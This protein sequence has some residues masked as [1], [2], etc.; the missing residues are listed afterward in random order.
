MKLKV[1]LSG[2]IHTN[3]RDE[4]IDK[5]RSKNLEIAKS[6]IINGIKDKLSIELLIEICK[7]PLQLIQVKKVAMV[8]S[9]VK[10]KSDLYYDNPKL[11]WSRL[12]RKI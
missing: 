12:Q 11:F 9:I 4:I 1:Y 7:R 8:N 6:I 3:W 5:C 10:M 2:E